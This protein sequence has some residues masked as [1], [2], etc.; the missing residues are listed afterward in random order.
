MRQFFN[1]VQ[2]GI[3][4]PV[5]L[6]Y[7]SQELLKSEAISALSKFVEPEGNNWNVEYFDGDKISAA[8]IVN[9]ASTAPFFAQRRLIVV[10]DVPWLSAKTARLE[11]AD[12]NKQDFLEPFL[13]Y[14]ENPVG[15]NIL[16]LTVKGEVDKRRKIIKALQKAGR[17]I[18]FADLDQNK[19][20]IWLKRRFAENG[21]KSS[22][23]AL[24]YL[25]LVAGNDLAFL[26]NEVDKISLYCA[27]KAQVELADVEA[28]ASRGAMLQIFSLIDAVADKEAEKSLILYQEMVKQGEAEQKILSM[29][30][31]Q[32]RDMLAV[33]ELQ[34][35]GLSSAQIASQLKLHPYVARKCAEKGRRFSRSQLMRAMELLLAADIANK[36]GQGDLDALLQMA[37]IRICAF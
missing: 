14:I 28:V 27:D 15:G 26:A 6:F 21:H 19:L 36:S 7:G 31:K 34:K 8:E 30:G 37:I 29:L 24:E 1:S 16:V 12:E 18:K 25:T 32:M 23:E 33:S 9:A 5:Y 17:V 35:Q 2:Q 4:S 20:M 10:K 13:R 11:S 3:V 22:N